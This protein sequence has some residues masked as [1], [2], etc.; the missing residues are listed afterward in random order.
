MKLPISVLAIALVAVGCKGGSGESAYVPTPP[1]KIEPAAVSSG[2]EASLFPMTVGNSWTY[3]ASTSVRA[4]AGTRQGARDV[5]FRVSKVD[6]TPNGKR[7]TIDLVVEGKVTEK[8]IW[9]LNSKGIYQASV[10][11]AN[12]RTFSTPIPSVMFPVEKGKKFSWKGSAGNANMT[13]ESEIIGSEEIDTE[14]KRLSAIAVDS[15]GTTLIGKNTEKVDRTV[16]FAP[17][18]GIVRIRETTVGKDAAMDLLISLKSYSV[19]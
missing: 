9:L 17:G 8:Q 2:Q 5:T 15:K 7:A 3:T 10:G 19:K 14:L 18:V 6:D 13:Y 12:P 4:K 11:G 16:W 1:P